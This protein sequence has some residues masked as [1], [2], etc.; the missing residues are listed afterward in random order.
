MPIT[1]KQIVKMSLVVAG[2]Y[3]LS[4]IVLVLSLLVIYSSLEETESQ[5]ISVIVCSSLVW[6]CGVYVLIRYNTKSNIRRFNELLNAEPAKE[7]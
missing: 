2:V 4:T 3:I 5:L 1:I 7:E 6:F